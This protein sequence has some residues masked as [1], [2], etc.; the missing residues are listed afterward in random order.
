MNASLFP[1]EMPAEPRSPLQLE[2]ATLRDWA[3]HQNDANYPKRRQHTEAEFDRAI[4]IARAEL[5]KQ[6]SRMGA[7]TPDQETAIETLRTSTVTRI[8]QLLGSLIEET[9][10]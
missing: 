6:R 2:T 9:I 3:V 1:T 5:K 7:L 4:G 8:S 10:H